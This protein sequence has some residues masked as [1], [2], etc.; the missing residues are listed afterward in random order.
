MKLL[1]IVVV[2]LAA[3]HPVSGQNSESNLEAGIYKSPT[4][5]YHATL[6]VSPFGGYKVL[7]LPNSVQIQDVS[8]VLWINDSMLVY[9]VSPIYGLPGIF[10]YD[11]TQ[12]KI[13]RIVAPRR[14][15]TKNPSGSDYFEL[16]SVD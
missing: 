8:G 4:G 12:Q 9:S 3:T 6:S 10:T 2:L 7:Q 1:R 16:K 14:V 15:G 13:A 11:C 5:Q